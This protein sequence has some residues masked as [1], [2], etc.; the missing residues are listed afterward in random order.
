MAIDLAVF[1]EKSKYLLS[2]LRFS[3]SVLIFFVSLGGE[4]R[5]KKYPLLVVSKDT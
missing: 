3:F 4:L 2:G 5:K 1:F